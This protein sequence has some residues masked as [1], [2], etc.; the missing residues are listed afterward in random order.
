M[1]RHRLGHITLAAAAMLMLSGC[2]TGATVP[3]PTPS[4]QETS[5]GVEAETMAP[6]ADVP[7]DVPNDPALRP[8]LTLVGC[9]AADGGW[10]AT[11]TLTNSGSEDAE[12]QVTVF[13]TNSTATVLGHGQTTLDIAAGSSADWSVQ[14]DFTAPEGTRCVVTGVATV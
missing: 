12:F 5:A 1:T 10:Q 6:D 13:F 3:T 4:A 11:G 9:D 7:H 2:T 8:D 14:A